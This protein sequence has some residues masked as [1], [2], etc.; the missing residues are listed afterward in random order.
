MAADG[1]RVALTALRHKP[2]TALVGIA[3]PESFFAMLRACGLT[4]EKTVALSDHHDFQS[5]ELAGYAGRTVLC[6]EKDAV[7][8]FAV[9]GQDG[10]QLLAVPLEFAPEPAFF[11]ALDAL[12]SQLP[13]S[14]GHKTA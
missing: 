11:A 12:L 7:K 3:S 5:G 8:L 9:P 10:V 6:T 14:H 2:L 1:S 4:L 13:S